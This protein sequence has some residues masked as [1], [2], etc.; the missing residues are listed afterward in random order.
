MFFLSHSIVSQVFNEK[1]NNVPWE[2][3][4]FNFIDCVSSEFL[5][6]FIQKIILII[7]FCFYYTFMQSIISFSNGSPK[8]AKKRERDDDA[9]SRYSTSTSGSHRDR[10]RDGRSHSTVSADNR[11]RRHRDDDVSSIAPSESVSVRSGSHGHRSRST[12]SQN[13]RSGNRNNNY[14]STVE[15]SRRPRDNSNY[16]PSRRSSEDDIATVIESVANDN[17]ATAITTEAFSHAYPNLPKDKLKQKAKSFIRDVIGEFIKVLKSKPT[18]G[19][20]GGSNQQSG[21]SSPP[22]DGRTI[23]KA[24]QITMAFVAKKYPA[25]ALVDIGKIIIPLILDGIKVW[26]NKENARDPNQ[27]SFRSKAKDTAIESVATYLSKQYP[28]AS[29]E[30]YSAHITDLVNGAIKVYDSVKSKSSEGS[31]S[32]KSNDQSRSRR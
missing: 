14:I 12:I 32:Q 4:R 26:R 19:Q 29:K 17:D 18:D 1:A 6:L 11:K 25:L 21:G 31:Q 8:E 24:I 3:T 9:S 28:I 2:I 20:P 13:P 7:S 30:V 27:P 15:S 10:H 5:I 16:P 22:P 23:N